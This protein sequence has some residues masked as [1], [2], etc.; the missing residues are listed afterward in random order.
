MKK[1]LL[2]LT[3]ITIVTAIGCSKNKS[4]I[5]EA[6]NSNTET[7]TVDVGT[8]KSFLASMFSLNENQ[9]NYNSSSKKFVVFDREQVSLEELS[10]IYNLQSASAP[11]I[12]TMK[13]PLKVNLM[14]LP[15]SDGGGGG[16]GGGVPPSP[17]PDYDPQILANGNFPNYYFDHIAVSQTDVNAGRVVSYS[18]T[19]AV[20]GKV[21][22]QYGNANNQIQVTVKVSAPVDGATG[23]VKPFKVEAALGIFNGGTPPTLL[24]PKVEF[25][26]ADYTN[27]A[28]FKDKT[29]TATLSGDVYYN[30]KL[31]GLVWGNASSSDMNY[32]DPA[33]P[34]TVTG[35]P[36]SGTNPTTPVTEQAGP[37][38]NIYRMYYT[39][40]RHFYT[41]S[42]VEKYNLL[43]S[44]QNHSLPSTN[45]WANLWPFG[46]TDRFWLDENVL[47]KAYKSSVLGTVPLYRYFNKSSGDHMYTI[48]PNEANGLPAIG[49]VAE[50]ISGYVYGSQVTNTIPVYRYLSNNSHG[51]F[52][53]YDY[54]ELGAGNSGYRYEGVAFYV[55]K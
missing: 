9:I 11:Q 36:A 15:P 35:I 44:N 22:L 7:S 25:T 5:P 23:K 14:P 55:L 12:T 31:I 4:L 24:N 29:F 53:T 19:N 6:I 20:N 52:Y 8:L 46:S 50:G 43:Q 2:F 33:Y 39:D 21:N 30:D 51:H 18:I 40:G 37:I 32:F 13:L 49:F 28:L 3:G 34:V 41:S 54:N 10:A 48:D 16:G 47:G 45:F 38:I 17:I 1:Y 42:A 27:G 26:Q